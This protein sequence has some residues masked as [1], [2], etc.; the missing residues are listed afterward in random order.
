MKN[1]QWIQHVNGTW[2]FALDPDNNQ[3]YDQAAEL[4]KQTIQVPGSWEEQGYGD[5]SNHDSIGTWMKEQSYEG[6]AWYVKEVTI[7]ASYEGRHM[8]LTING[9]RFGSELWLDGVRVGQDESLTTPHRYDITRQAKPG[10]TQ[11]IVIRLDTHMRYDLDESHIHSYHT[12]TNWGGITGGIEIEGVLPDT[13]ESIIMQPDATERSVDVA[14]TLRHDHHEQEKR[15]TIRVQVLQQDGTV[16]CQDTKVIRNDSNDPSQLQTSF[17][18]SLGEQAQ[19]WSPDNPYL[20]QLELTL[21]HDDDVY[22][23]TY[24]T[25][26]LRSIK[27]GKRQMLL[28]DQP[29]FLTGYVDCSVFPQ[30]GYPV[31]NKAHYAKQFDIVKQYGFNHVRLHGWTPPKPFWEAADEAGMLV[32]TELPHWGLTYRHRQ[33]ES[34]ED[35]H[36]FLKQEMERILNMLH[37]HPSFVMFSM[38]NELISSE[39][40]P[41]LNALVHH[42]QKLDPTRLYTDNAGFGELPA[43]DRAGDFFIPTL[44]HHPPYHIE[45]AA[46]PDT[47]QDFSE[48]TRLEDKPIIAHEHGQF[49]TYVRPQEAEKYHGVLEP[50]W[51]KMIRETLTFKGLDHRIDDFYEA[52]CKHTIRTLKEAMEKARRTPGLSGI[53]LL[54]VRDFPGQGHATVGVLD[55]F[56]DDKNMI[57]PEQFRQFNDQTVLL[58]RSKERTLFNQEALH[59][60]I[61]VSHFNS[62][63][64]Q[65]T[66]TWSV[67][68]ESETIA[69]GEQVIE[70]LPGGQVT[71]VAQMSVTIPNGPSRQLVLSATL[72]LDGVTYTN[73][74]D[75]WT[76]ERA[77]IQ[78]P[79]ER[80]WTNEAALQSTLYGARFEK[81]I[82]MKQFSYKAEKQVDLAISSQLSRDVL[83]F[84]IDGGSV[85][86][87]PQSGNQY[88]EVMTKY[89]PIFW[90][91]LWFPEQTGATM[92]MH[93]H[94]HPALARF[95]HDG[96]TNWHWYHLINHTVALNLDMFEDVEPIIEVVDNFNRAKRLAYAFEARVGK[97]KIFVA[98]LNVLDRTTMKR[99]EVQSFLTE[100]INYLTSDEF[101]PRATVRPGELLG[102]F[103]LKAPRMNI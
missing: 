26:G 3:R 80:I 7:P 34:P 17:Q 84:L 32:Q 101:Q 11:R 46:H 64:S 60:H 47:T 86:L 43:R 30:T 49:T 94:N 18:L 50:N 63:S 87:I 66:L 14:V 4:P 19:L 1:E 82:G 69:T 9:L 85:L 10:A 36:Q 97:G 58:M 90:N 8:Y 38:G 91:Y 52:S 2:Y 39:G 100:L 27:T 12:S 15:K 81:V 31:W 75:F 76:F 51:L 99:P 62:L 44:N 48:V 45:D 20:Y 77:E 55:V 24:R 59:A 102:M 21:M 65:G 40:H 54:D 68:D 89:L 25:F 41:Q 79:I 74:W 96:F 23:R 28:N 88:D 93:I 29:I 16:I 73:A 61:D 35:V 70:E 71:E 67:I 56:W 95:P 103:K 53:Q 42:G 13:F 22:D 98:S 92:G 72:N 83:Q 5:P 78:N 33:K 57:S 37:A 6:V